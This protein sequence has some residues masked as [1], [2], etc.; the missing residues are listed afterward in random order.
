[1]CKGFLTRGK[2]LTVENGANYIVGYCASLAA[3]ANQ[4]LDE[5]KET[6]DWEMGVDSA[7]LAGGDFCVKETIKRYKKVNSDSANTGSISEANAQH[8]QQEASKLRAQISNLQNSNRNMLGESLGSLNLRDLKNLESKV[9]RGI[10]RVRSKKNELL[11]AE[12]EFMQKREVDLHSNNQYLR[13]KIAETERAQ[14]DMNLMPGSSDYELVSA[15]PFDA[16]TFLQVNGLQLNN[17]YPRQEQRPLQ[18]V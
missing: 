10:S 17:H 13:S 11:F 7:L 3:A 1:M 14:H 5:I 9:E 2:N 15:Q 6:S 12:I 16:R 18:L 4:C 8:Y